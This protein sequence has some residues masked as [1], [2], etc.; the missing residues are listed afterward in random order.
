MRRKRRG[1]EVELI[2]PKMQRFESRRPNYRLTTTWQAI[3]PTMCKPVLIDTFRRN[4]MYK[5][6]IAAVLILAS[7]AP[8][9]ARQK[10]H[11][12]A[13]KSNVVRRTSGTRHTLA[14]VPTSAIGSGGIRLPQR[15]LKIHRSSLPL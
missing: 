15:L 13:G 14:A 7:L 5:L 4:N 6:L 3:S 10:A 11:N 9:S 2:F 1:V 12:A 8:A